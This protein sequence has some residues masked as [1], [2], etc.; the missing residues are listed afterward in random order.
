MFERNR[1]HNISIILAE[2]VS[3]GLDLALDLGLGGLGGA[4]A[5]L[6]TTIYVLEAIKL[7]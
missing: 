4:G 3:D 2:G 5:G 6:D 7:I 1:T